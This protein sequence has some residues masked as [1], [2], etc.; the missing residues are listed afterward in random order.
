MTSSR[1]SDPTSPHAATPHAAPPDTVPFDTVTL[2]I[3]GPAHGGAAVARFGDDAGER[4]GQVVFVR[5]ALPGET[6]VPVNLD[7]AT[8]SSRRRFLTGEVADV[9]GI[10]GPS[11][12]RVTPVC[13]AAAAGAGCCDL[14]YVDAEGSLSWKRRV[15]EDQFTRIGHLDLGQVAVTAQSATPYT[16]Y[17]TRVRLGVGPD[18]RAGLRRRNSHGIVPVSD[19]IC[20][21]WAPALADG[22]AR[23]LDAAGLT[24]GAEVCVAL[25]DDGQRSI[26]ELVKEHA[27]G[28]SH[29]RG[30]RGARGRRDHRR[31]NGAQRRRTRRR[32]IAGDGTVTHI[33]NG[34]NWTVPV[35]AFWQAHVEAP[36][37]YHRWIADTLAEA[38]E[39]AGLDHDTVASAWDLYG[40]AGVLAAALAD[41]LPGADVD[42]VDV[43]SEATESGR[44][45]LAGRS[46]RF[47][48][49]D[50][51]DRLSDL[52]GGIDGQ[53][54]YAVVLDPPR[55]G[56]GDR[57][58]ERVAARHP[59]HILHIGC[60][61]ATAARDAELLA[62]SGYRPVSLT[63]VDAFG[64]TH[65]VEVLAHY[66]PVTPVPEQ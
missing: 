16:G 50:V 60:D 37:R 46:V 22:L 36:V 15:V 59:R 57:V 8:P 62:V 25:G 40:G 17:R 10:T 21:Q 39:A 27:P 58:L 55:T 28:D 41:A 24:P 7:P 32:V 42:C 13:P 63:V 9:A 23:D 4:S 51:A 11:S 26:V 47:F 6:G 61:P 43:A 45:A 44:R 65:H 3:G 64:L 48:D 1:P 35:E 52:T 66:V 49:G 12:H 34:V 54:P 14:D 5:G 18:G 33:V 19:A 30:G 38:A 53:P 29:T 20:A 56:A 2:D 31:R